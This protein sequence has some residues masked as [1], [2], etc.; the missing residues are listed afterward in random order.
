MIIF[1]TLQFCQCLRTFCRVTITLSMKWAISFDRDYFNKH[2]CFT[3]LGDGIVKK[4]K[5]LQITY[6]NTSKFT[7]VGSQDPNS[8]LNEVFSSSKKEAEIGIM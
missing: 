2:Q 5:G 1:S 6:S 3:H 4:A 8:S 7:D